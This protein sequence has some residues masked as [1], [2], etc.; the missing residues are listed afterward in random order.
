VDKIFDFLFLDHYELSRISD[1]IIT[2]KCGIW[3]HDHNKAS[4]KQQSL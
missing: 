4:S 2:S 3:N 1:S